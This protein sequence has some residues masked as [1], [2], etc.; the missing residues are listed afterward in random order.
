MYTPIVTCEYCGS[1]LKVDL[2][3]EDRGI[4]HSCGC[5]ESFK[6][7]EKQHHLEIERRKRLRR[8]GQ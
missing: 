5:E 1:T 3:S 7:W 4:M 2:I 8:G 6:N